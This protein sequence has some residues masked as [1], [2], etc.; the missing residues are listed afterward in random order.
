MCFEV[1]SSYFFIEQD[2]VLKTDVA[3]KGFHCGIERER[4]LRYLCMY[5]FE[6]QN[7]AISSNNFI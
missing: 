4:Q 5:L 3:D 2:E 1:D 6:E 7:L